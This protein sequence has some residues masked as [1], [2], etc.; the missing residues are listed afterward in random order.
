M[1]VCGWSHA[2]GA[3]YQLN[4]S[5]FFMSPIVSKKKKKN[6]AQVWGNMATD[7]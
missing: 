5:A 7:S 6:L 4:D 3:D 2:L 1:D